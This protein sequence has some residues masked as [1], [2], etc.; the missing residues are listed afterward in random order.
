MCEY[1]ADLM[2]MER[3]LVAFQNVTF[4]QF[5]VALYMEGLTK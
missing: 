3:E 4:E 5:H 2:A 1:L